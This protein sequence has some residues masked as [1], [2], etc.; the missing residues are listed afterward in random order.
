MDTILVNLVLFAAVLFLARWIHRNLFT[1]DKKSTFAAC[2]ACDA[3]APAESP[4]LEKTQSTSST[5]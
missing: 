1:R 2:D 5:T 4:K 3:C